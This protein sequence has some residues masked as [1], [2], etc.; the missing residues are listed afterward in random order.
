MLPS[1]NRD[2]AANEVMRDLDGRFRKPLSIYFR[3]R[4]AG[5][6]Q[7]AEDLT[8]EV[9][10]RLAR[11]PDR[12]NGE[13]LEG[14]VFKIAGSVLADWRRKRATHKADAHENLDHTLE[15]VTF[16]SILIE[17]RSP[18]RVLSGKEALQSLERALAQ[19]EERTRRIFLLYRLGGVQQSDIARRVGISIS[20]VERE[21]QKALAHIG[22]NFP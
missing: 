13:T 22:K 10:L 21:I 2:I 8:Q 7:E 9:F 11:R 17:D 14:Y 6:H 20:T 4:L 3:R 5:N 12:N 15:G 1:Q 16:P 18:E 19:L